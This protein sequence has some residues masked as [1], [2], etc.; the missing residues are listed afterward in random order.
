MRRLLISTSLFI[1]LFTIA[2]GTIESATIFFIDSYHEGYEWSD[3]I[4]QGVLDGI[5]SEDVELVI[6]RMD[7]KRITNESYLLAEGLRVKKLIDSISPDVVIACDDNASKY[8]TE[9]YLKNSDIP[10][11]FCGVNWDASVYGYPWENTTGM[12]EV[13]LVQELIRQLSR[14][15]RERSPRVGYLAS[16]T[17]TERKESDHY[18]TQLGIQL[19]REIFVDSYE[20]WKNG[21]L[22]IQEDVDILIVGTFVLPDFNN[23]EAEIFVQEN[24]RIPTGTLNDF[25]MPY[26]LMG[27][28]K[29]PE[30]FGF[31]SAGAALRILNGDNPRDIPLTT[32]KQSELILNMEIAD[33]L[34]VVFGIDLLRYAT[35]IR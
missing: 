22:E 35:I 12:I 21:F 16:D 18:K 15:T 29:N 26:A 11:V 17:F 24:T 28:M 10:I 19:T 2:I 31:W 32:N 7:T 14:Y 1:V 33:K 23:R 3:R 9:P 13:N 4:I 25:L 34:D 27:Y 8:V 20:E 6:H 30:E 5:E